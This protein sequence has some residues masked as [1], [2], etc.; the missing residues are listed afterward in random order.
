MSVAERKLREKEMIRKKII[1][2]ALQLVKNEGWESLSIRKIADAI[3]YSAP[4]IYDH[5]ANKE[6][7]LFEISQDGFKLLLSNIHK[8]ISKKASP[9]EELKALVD[10]YWKFALKN[11]SYF[12]LMFGVGMPCCG[13]GKMKTEFGAL[14]DIIY[15][16]IKKIIVEKKTN[17]ESAC[18]KTHAFWS[19]IH[20]FTSIMIA[21]S[22]DVPQTMNVS[23]L[24][25]MVVNI[26][27]NL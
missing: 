6:A 17:I 25:Q 11:R 10:T 16:I 15:E 19:A 14:Q 22:A 3:E 23:V 20:G 1:D 13:E 21:R 5:F 4:V 24:D 27:E 8:A 26:I 7:I 2:A 18:Y 12:K 9:R